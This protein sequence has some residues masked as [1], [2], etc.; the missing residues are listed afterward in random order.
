MIGTCCG[1]NSMGNDA[2]T[3]NL[4]EMNCDPSVCAYVY[5]I[6]NVKQPS[7]QICMLKIK[8]YVVQTRGAISYTF[9]D[10]ATDFPLAINKLFLK[11]SLR[12]MIIITLL[13]RSLL[14][15]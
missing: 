6:D 1:I 13:K 11:C 3:R 12:Y 7:C 9:A 8:L 15:M 4:T 14:I 5:K 10:D 2:E